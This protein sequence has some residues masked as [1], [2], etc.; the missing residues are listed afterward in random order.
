MS[1][2]YSDHKRLGHHS[3]LIPSRTY[4]YALS[5]AFFASVPYPYQR[6]YR[7]HVRQALSW[8]NGFV[9][10]F[11]KGQTG[12][13][14]FSTRIA[15]TVLHKLAKL[16]VGR[17]LLFDDDGKA[18]NETID[19]FG[20]KGLD[21][22]HFIELYSKKDNWSSKLKL[23]TEWTYAGGT[24][25]LKLDSVSGK[26]VLEPLRTDEFLFDT[27]HHGE[28]VKSSALIYTETDTATRA[29]GEKG[30]E[31]YYLFEERKYAEN[32]KP[33]YRLAIK[34]GTGHDLGFK[35][36]DFHSADQD[37]KSC[38]KHIREKFVR[39]FP[40]IMF[41][42]WQELPFDTIGFWIIKAT[43]GVSFAPSLP[44]GESL[45]TNC[46]HILQG[47]DF[48]YTALMTDMYLGRGKIIVPQHMQNPQ[49]NMDWDDYGHFRGFDTFLTTM[50]PYVNP[51]DQKPLEIQFD[52]RSEDWKEIRNHLLQLLATNLGVSERT[53]ATYLVPA[54]EKP[55]NYEISADEDAT[56]AFVE[57][58]RD[59]LSRVFDEILEEILNF[60][61]FE[62]RVSVKFSKIG[63]QNQQ[64]LLNNVTLKWQNGLI[65]HR[66]ALEE[67]YPDKTEDQITKIIELKKKESE[68]KQEQKE[69]EVGNDII[70]NSEQ[71]M[72]EGSQ[73]LQVERD[74][75]D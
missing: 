74:E 27:D 25:A 51:S 66:T 60:Y 3:G 17:K 30:K 14:Y 23:A 67:L 31:L 59:R 70:K 1:E 72:R 50:I 19:M 41:N 55:S 37:F 33:M 63:L 20:K 43:D 56:A 35:D 21:P 11:H 15:Y 32:G 69:K 9:D 38:P 46:F 22:L 39:R 12:D 36:V 75:K 8:Y 13:T 34:R 58:K 40:R 42:E 7:S 24:S 16:T 44:H 49:S 47:Y 5:E 4:T 61:G 64:N 73:G 62:S 10:W 57:D 29:G 65:D 6:F 28:V 26:L 48:F 53:I 18:S 71:Q 52:L 68:Y 54:S 45:L 2:Q